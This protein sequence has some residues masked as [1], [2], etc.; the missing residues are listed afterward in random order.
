MSKNKIKYENQEN[1]HLDGS[2]ENAY[3][4]YS[5]KLF[6]GMRNNVSSKGS[7]YRMMRMDIIV[8]GQSE[9]FPMPLPSSSEIPRLDQ[10]LKM[11]IKSI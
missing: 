11:Y 9:L 3:M 6:N 1:W 2:A 5:S 7:I 8:R 4:L 10:R